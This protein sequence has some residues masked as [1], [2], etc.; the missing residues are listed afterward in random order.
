MNIWQRGTNYRVSILC[1]TLVFF[2]LALRCYRIKADA[3]HAFDHSFYDEGRKVFNARNMAL[4]GKPTLGKQPPWGVLY[5]P[6]FTGLYYTFFRLFTVST[7]T[8]RMLSACICV[9]AVI[10]F[11]LIVRKPGGAQADSAALLATLLFASDFPYFIYSRLALPESMCVFMVTLS[12]FIYK[13]LQKSSFVFHFMFGAFIV[14]LPMTKP[15]LFPYVIG[16]FVVEL[17][18]KKH[19][20]FL[21]G[22]CFVPTIMCSL[23]FMLGREQEL[24]LLYKSLRFNSL[25]IYSKRHVSFLLY[26]LKHAPANFF[27]TVFGWLSGFATEHPGG[28]MFIFPFLWLRRKNMDGDSGNYRLVGTLFCTASACILYMFLFISARKWYMLPLMPLLYII[29]A[30]VMRA[31]FESPKALMKRE[32]TPLSK[33]E[34]YYMAAALWL[35]LL[36]IMPMIQIK[37]GEGGVAFMNYHID[38]P[39]FSVNF[40]SVISAIF[41]RYD[42]WWHSRYSFLSLMLCLVL[43][44]IMLLFRNAAGY[45]VSRHGRVCLRVFIALLLTLHF[46]VNTVRYISWLGS[47]R[48]Y[49]YNAAKRIESLVPS[50]SIICGASF[51]SLEN[52]NRMFYRGFSMEHFEKA[53]YFLLAKK[54]KEVFA[55]YLKELAVFPFTW[56][57]TYR[58]FY[59]KERPRGKMKRLLYR[60]IYA[61]EI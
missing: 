8:A 12:I 19:I 15:T 1:F 61:Q 13:K 51:L 11:Y 49:K 6:A 58:L 21:A 10:L 53:E 57:R 30:S 56:N 5:T 18:N 26:V 38:I 48:S 24:L 35:F 60:F 28:V 39:F 42:W 2:C 34:I 50:S 33:T 4:F 32:H 45:S 55:K 31:A 52:K 22:I 9:L 14:L 46:G 17:I 7:K 27:I 47:A 41:G 36:S 16:F 20:P 3:P 43:A 23:L 25:A 29:G 40:L 37:S 44:L 54:N 59:M